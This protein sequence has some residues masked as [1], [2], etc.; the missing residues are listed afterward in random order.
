MKLYDG[1]VLILLALISIGYVTYIVKNQEPKQEVA[2]Q[3][4][5]V[6]ESGR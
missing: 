2:Q 6:Q 5:V 4:P 1:G 3:Q